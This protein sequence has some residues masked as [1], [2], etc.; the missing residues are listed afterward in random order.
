MLDITD[1]TE[2]NEYTNNSCDLSRKTGTTVTIT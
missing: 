1:K 2:Y